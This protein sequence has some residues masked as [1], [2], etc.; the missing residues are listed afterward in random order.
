[1]A[2]QDH[3]SGAAAF[4]QLY[5][6][7]DDV[8]HTYAKRFGLSEAALLLLCALVESPE[9]PSQRQLASE[10]HYPPQTVN[11]ILKRLEADGL[12]CLMEAPADRRSKR[13]CFTEAG[14]AFAARVIAPLLAAEE[15][16]FSAL[17]E[18]E[19]R[20]LLALT[21]KYIRLLREEID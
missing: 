15:R 7:S 14:Q 2:Q 10:W 9:P 13:V 1:M 5:K 21:K 18:D 3:I 8:Y 19:Q 11:S 16:A 20:L 4:N 6:E 17:T 12:L